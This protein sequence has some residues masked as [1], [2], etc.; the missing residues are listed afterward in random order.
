MDGGLYFVEA[1]HYA[2]STI[3]SIDKILYYGNT[4]LQNMLIA[5]SNTIGIFLALDY[6]VQS[7]EADAYVYHE[8][9]VH[10]CMTA[11]DNPKRAL[12]I[13]GGEGTTAAELL[14]YKNLE[15]DWVE[16]DDEVVEKCREFLPYALKKDDRRVKL[17]IRDGIE[18]VKTTKEKYDLILGDMIEPYI[19]PISNS[20]YSK[21]FAE[22]IYNRLTDNG[23]YVTLSWEKKG[24]D[25]EH[26]LK[27]RYLSKI[28]K[29]VRPIHFFMPGFS[30]DF[31]L[32]IASKM[33]DP[34]K[35]ED[36]DISERIGNFRNDLKFY[37]EESH[38]SLF[39]FR[40]YSEKNP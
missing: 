7:S 16:I 18:F 33:H 21:E 8:S 4:K 13:G 35:T 20:I 9:L 25:W 31:T 32:T 2:S 23:M 28:F 30:I 22:T 36:K 12:I 38:R 40:T 24:D 26:A 17:F 5:H 39:D 15:I 34:L 3:R 6:Q 10:T 14:K 27:P 29:V 1:T 19:N 11:I 37:N